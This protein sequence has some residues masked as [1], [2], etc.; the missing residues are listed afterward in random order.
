[1]SVVEA[2]RP[3]LKKAKADFK[4][5]DCDIHPNV[6]GGMTGVFPY[7]TEAW[8]RRF[9]RKNAALMDLALTM[10]FQHPKGT[11]WR[12]DLREENGDL[13]GTDPK[14]VLHEHMA[15][16]NS[17]AAV[18]NSL[19]SAGV[20]A[21]I[22]S[23]DESIVLASAFND[24]F[25]DKWLTVDKRFRYAMMVPAQDI[26]AS[27]AEVRRIGKH[28]GVSAIQIPLINI[29][30]GYRYY[31]PLYAVAQEFD[32][33]LYI[34]P[35]GGDQI[36]QCTPASAGGN[37]DTYIERY[38]TIGQIAEA[39][40]NSLIMS[41]T[42]EQFPQLKVMFVEWGFAWVLHLTWRMDRAWRALRHETPWV[43]KWPSDYINKHIRITTQPI[44]E[45]RDPSHLEHFFKIAGMDIFCF[46]TDFP[47]WD[48]DYP[49]QTLRFLSPADRQKYFYDNAVNFLRLD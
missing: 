46:S 9:V 39:N 11:A 42:F 21:A 44:D 49:D 10:R 37:P 20:C 34:H 23:V 29:L 7:L 33:P 1:M 16:M 31:W 47:H 26:E 41:G 30:M 6:R 12:D 24:Y 18:L 32:L 14:V 17:E 35:S 40:L 8:R 38:C 5:I 48:G 28:P 25:L 22:S 19:Q 3:Y 2:D 27:V 43:K 15:L 13:G 36:Y 45:P 4:M